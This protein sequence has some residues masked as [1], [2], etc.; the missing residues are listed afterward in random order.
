MS[1]QKRKKILMKVNEMQEVEVS[2]ISLVKNAANRSPFKFLKSQKKDGN[3]H[4]NLR[5]LFGKS[6]PKPVKP[7]IITL[8]AK[9]E[10]VKGLVNTLTQEG[11]K[12][13]KQD[14]LDGATTL[15][16]TDYDNENTVIFKMSDDIAIGV[17]DIAK[18][19]SSWGEDESFIKN[20]AIS[21]F[22]PGVRVATDVFIST[23]EKIMFKAD[24]ATPP[25]E[26]IKVLTNDFSKYVR[27]L[28]SKLPA[29]AFK[30]DGMIL[31][32]DEVVGKKEEAVIKDD[33]KKDADV[34]EDK[35]AEIITKADVA[36]L[37]DMKLKEDTKNVTMLLNES[38]KK[39]DAAI[40]SLTEQFTNV[41]DALAGVVNL[42]VKADVANVKKSEPSIFDSALDFAGFNE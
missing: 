38:V 6:E 11:I 9:T 8:V 4:V 1:K 28:T 42:G 27:M 2:H 26:A 37:I 33:G 13:T 34:Q 36:E 14:D 18:S 10:K 32:T 3:M 5:T 15:H 25:T 24:T 17:T 22:F 35:Q 29:E 23:L 21:G 7:G 16:L 20:M 39:S 12:V 19:F 30:Y 41:T 31:K 40:A